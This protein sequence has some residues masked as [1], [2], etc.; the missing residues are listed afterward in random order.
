[1]TGIALARPAR[2][3]EGVRR[4][5]MR[6]PLLAI[7]PNDRLLLRPRPP[8]ARHRHTLREQPSCR[9]PALTTPSFG[10]DVAFATV[11]HEKSETARQE[12]T[13]DDADA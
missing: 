3:H 1:V 6:D 10:F 5:E 9:T 7:E 4:I 13:I 8:N 12:P 11:C 2:L